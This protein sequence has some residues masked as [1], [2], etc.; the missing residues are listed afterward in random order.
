MQILVE[1][2][3]LALIVIMC[4]GLAL[5]QIKIFGFKLGVAAVLFVGLGLATLEPGIQIPPLIYI[6]G[7]ALFVYTIGLESG[8][9]FFASLKS[10]GIRHN[11]FG[12]I[13]LAVI[14][15][16]AFL[17]VKFLPVDSVEGAGTFTGALTNTPAMAAVVDALPTLFTDPDELQAKLEMP[18]IG[19][20]LAYPIGVLA[21]IAS[22]AIMAKVFRIDHQQEAIDAGVAAKPLHTRD[23][24]VTKPGLPSVT[25]MPH[26]FK[27]DIIVSRIEHK[28]RL[29]VPELGDTAEVGDVLSVV[30]TEEE[31][32]LAVEK[33]GEL[34]PGD[35]THDTRLDFR[36]IF[37][38]APD[39]CGTPL[40]SLHK[41][42]EGMIITR[43]RRGDLDM[44]ASPDMKLELGD[45]VRVVATPDRID[46]ATKF[47][48]DSYK[49][50]SDVNLLPMFVGLLLGILVGMIPFP[51]PGGGSLSLGSAGGPL[52]V[53]LILGALGRTGPLVWPI[54]YS[55]NL[56]FR[57]V[58]LALFLA[59]IGTTAGKGFKEA[60]AQPSSLVVLGLAA[61]IAFS[62]ALVT[63]IV[64]YKFL[65][66][67]FGQTA[68]ILAGLQTH[69]AVLTYVNDQAKNELPGMGYTTV[70]PMAMVAKIVLAQILIVALV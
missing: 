47:F 54:P 22:I 16:E 36:R 30:C 69:P 68:G 58:G 5:G 27:L 10:V 23:I 64:G 19:Y 63:L 7:L 56:A 34:V 48:G 8:P 18:V 20:S 50:L 44:V 32:P 2:Q 26:E 17:L 33:I 59:G 41:K 43:V 40:S 66:I 70:Y 39:V 4:V 51:M 6:V 31:L 46:R 49:K 28:G 25:D 61:I 55:A 62:S 1:N 65:R 21:V 15:I 60:L 29:F 42:M 11:I 35:P 53:A 14:A 38:S 45:R 13:V 67:P 9:E 37:V 3:L 52:I 24:R 57:T 12:F